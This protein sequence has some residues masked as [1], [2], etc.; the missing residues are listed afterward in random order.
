MARRE[1]SGSK[2]ERNKS[3][4]D[5]PTHAPESGEPREQGGRAEQRRA[6]GAKRTGADRPTDSVERAPESGRHNA[7]PD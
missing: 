7:T 1:Q 4:D 2:A 3:N 5:S 6:A